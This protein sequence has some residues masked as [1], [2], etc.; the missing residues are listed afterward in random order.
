MKTDIK[1]LETPGWA[2][3]ALLDSGEGRKLERYGPVITDRPDAQAIWAK[4][5]PQ[6]WD[7]AL[8]IFSADNDEEGAGRWKRAPGENDEWSMSFDDVRFICRFSAFRH[9]G[10]FPEQV[11]HWAWFANRIRAAK[12]PL[13]ILNLFGYTGIASLVAAAAGAQVTHVDASK[14]AIAWA[15]ENQTL[16]GLDEKSIRW[17]CDDAVK[18]V[19]REGRRGNV[20][21][22]IILDPPKYGRGPKGEVWQIMD[23]LP[24]LLDDCTQILSPKADFMILSAYAIRASF[25]MTHEMMRDRLSDRAGTLTSGELVL[26]QNSEANDRRLSTSLYSRWEA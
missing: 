12:R 3:Y 18:F 16:S 24:G 23:D 22:G 1:M 20:Y 8:A 4:S 7:D 6:L 25:F 21:D 11:A 17:I 9:V 14:K 26:V 2:D 19:A 13:K 15:R 5:A 10:V